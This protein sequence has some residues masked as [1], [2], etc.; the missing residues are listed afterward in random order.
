MRTSGDETQRVDEVEGTEASCSPTCSCKPRALS[1]RGKTI[2][3]L[4]VALAAVAVVMGSANRARTETDTGQE[5]FATDPVMTPAKAT[6]AT[7]EQATATEEQPWEA[8]IWGKPLASLESLNEVAAEKDAVFVFLAAEGGEQ[9]R[10]ITGEV[11]AAARK[12]QLRGTSIGAYTL[13]KDVQDYTQVTSQV[14]APCVLVM[15]KGAGAS[16]VEG[17]EITEAK[18][19]EALVSASRPSGCAPSDCAPSGCAPSGCQ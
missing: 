4:V 2:I 19:L 7:N 5:A 12:A 14:P 18:L 3:C 9:T 6:S 11:E 15:V 1:T 17:G 16:A 10:I 13:D 8:V